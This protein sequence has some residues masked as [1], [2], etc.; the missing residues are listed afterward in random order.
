MKPKSY[1]RI[2]FFWILNSQRNENFF[3]EY[4]F[5]NRLIQLSINLKHNA[6]YK[7]KYFLGEDGYPGSL[8]EKGWPGLPGESGTIGASGKIK[9]LNTDAKC[10]LYQQ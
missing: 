6:C 7:N 1:F 9:F 3:Y 5:L 8:G 4:S 2:F 10:S